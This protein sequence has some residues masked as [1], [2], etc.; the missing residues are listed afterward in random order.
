M[1]ADKD[2]TKTTPDKA[3]A[4]TSKAAAKLEGPPSRGWVDDAV[5]DILEAKKAGADF[6][7]LPHETQ[8]ILGEVLTRD[9][10]SRARGAHELD[11]IKR[12]HK[13]ARTQLNAIRSGN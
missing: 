8:Q 1:S 13:H 2:N 3:P 5:D 11:H 6:S 4:P 7:T 12:A 9:E 10:G